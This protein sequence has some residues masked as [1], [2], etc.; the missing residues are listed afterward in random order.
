MELF[1]YISLHACTCCVVLPFV[2]LACIGSVGMQRTGKEVKYS[3]C[4]LFWEAEEVQV[5]V[6][7]SCNL[8]I[9]WQN[10]FLFPIPL[11]K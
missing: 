9:K 1:K 4:L 2:R 10:L 6:E 8:E 7:S 3:T 11:Q 5:M